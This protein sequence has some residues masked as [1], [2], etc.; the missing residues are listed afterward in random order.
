MQINEK[1]AFVAINSLFAM[2]QLRIFL[3]T[4]IFIGTAYGQHE[5]HQKMPSMKSHSMKSE[6]PMGPKDCSEME[7]WDYSTASCRQLAMA[8]MPMSMWMLHGNAFLVQT[9]Q[10]GPRGHDRFAVPNMI[11]SEVGRSVGDRHYVDA[12]LMLTFEKWTFPKEGYPEVFQIGE[13]NED[14]QPYIDGQ[15]PHS[16]PVMGLTFS[17]TIRLAERRD[18]LKLFFALRGQATDGPIA[19]MHRPSGMVNP[20]A[21]LGHHIGQD[22]SHITSTVLGASLGLGRIRIEASAFHGEEPEPTKVDLPMGELNSYAGRLI[23]EFSDHVSAMASAA[24]VKEPEHDDPTLDKVYRYSASTYIQHHLNNGWMLHDAFVFGLV[25]NYDHISALRSFLYEF[26][27]HSDQPS[28][29]WGRIEFVERTGAQ[30]NITTIPRPL[31]PHYVTALTAGYTYDLTK[32]QD[33]KL[34]LGASV[35]KNFV[36]S[37][38]KDAYGGD[39]WSGKIFVQISGMKMGDFGQLK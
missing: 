8:G 35:T 38:F 37:V 22:V 16:S 39:P 32:F 29:Y 27:L 11:M 20:D 13:K 30:L 1:T 34:G 12:N 15:H 36:P 4:M 25:N 23:Y 26:W 19:F 2:N 18:Y 3:I 17:D 10:E 6:M 14:G 28:N 24:L 7:V 5:D 31:D 9:Y 21:P 33:G